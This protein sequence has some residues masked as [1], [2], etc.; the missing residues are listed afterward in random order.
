MMKAFLAA[1]AAVWMSQ[2]AD[3]ADIRIV[4][5]DSIL[6][7]PANPGRSYSDFVVHGVAVRADE[8]ETFEVDRVLVQVFSGDQ[9]QITQEI[10]G[11]QLAANSAALMG[12]PVP[13]MIAGQLLDRGGLAGLFGQATEA[14]TSARIRANQALVSG[15]HYFAFQGEADRLRVTVHGRDN[16]GNAVVISREVPISRHRSAIEYRAPLRGTWLMQAIPSLQSHHRFNPSTEFAVD[17]FKVDAEGQMQQGSPL[18]AENFYG[19]GADVLAAADG[20]VVLVTDGEVQDREMMLRRPD[21]TPQSAGER[22][23]AYNLRRMA[24]N[25]ERAAAG[26][27]VV[28]RHER[29]GSVEYSAYGHLRSGVIARPGQRVRQGEI[30]GHVGDTG[31]SPAVHLHFQVNAGPDPFATKSLPVR[32]AGMRNAGGNNELGRFVTSE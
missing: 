14:A 17:F 7:N 25:F 10:S 31:D 5:A 32:F 22:I 9:A 2:A 23:G 11:A 1:A 16:E 28:L 30:I 3:A 26:N 15:R 4:P 29:E 24:S 6:A 20:E 21:E 19:Y 18:N 13:A 8:G 12:A 27:L